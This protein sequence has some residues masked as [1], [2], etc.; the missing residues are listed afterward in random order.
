MQIIEKVLQSE[1]LHGTQIE[2]LRWPYKSSI[3]KAITSG[4]QV[5]WHHKPQAKPDK[6]ERRTYKPEIYDF[7]FIWFRW[8]KALLC[9]P[10][11]KRVQKVMALQIEDLYGQRTCSPCPKGMGQPT[12]VDLS[13]P[14][15]ALQ[16]FL[17]V[18]IYDLQE[19]LHLHNQRTCVFF[20]FGSQCK[21]TIPL[22]AAVK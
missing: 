7:W 18:Q 4:D 15:K 2:D 5:R 12:Q 21:A 9:N 22:L 6:P 16:I 13:L 11:V 19:D 8:S 17:Q 3:C 14:C 20:C 1:A 10:L